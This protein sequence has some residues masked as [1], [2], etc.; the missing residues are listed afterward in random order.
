MTD[1][2]KAGYINECLGLGTISVLKINEL[3][4]ETLKE[5]EEINHG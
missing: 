5:M 2:E 1:Y 3:I 4:D